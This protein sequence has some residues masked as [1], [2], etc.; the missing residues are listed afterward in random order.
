MAWQPWSWWWQPAVNHKSVI[1][2]AQPNILF[3]MKEWMRL[4]VFSLP[5]LR[6]FPKM[7]EAW[8]FRIIPRWRSYEMQ[9]MLTVVRQKRSVSRKV[10]GRTNTTDADRTYAIG[11][12]GPDEKRQWYYELNPPCTRFP[13]ILY[14]GQVNHTSSHPCLRGLSTD[15][16]RGRNSPSGLILLRQ[17]I[18]PMPKTMVPSTRNVARPSAHVKLWHAGK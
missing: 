12:W 16:Y 10:H 6:A 7:Q 18:L 3:Y 14:K 5:H 9:H 17:N 8:L 1:H 11:L 2:L 4:P 13:Q 15:S